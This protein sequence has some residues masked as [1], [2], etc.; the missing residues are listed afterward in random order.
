MPSIRFFV[1]VYAITLLSLPHR[2]YSDPVL[3][4]STRLEVTQPV[5]GQNWKLF[6]YSLLPNSEFSVYATSPSHHEFVIAQGETDFGGFAEVGITIAEL[7]G[8]VGQDL[9]IHVVV[10]N[11]Q[12]SSASEKSY[13]QFSG[14]G[15]ENPDTAFTP[16]SLEAFADLSSNG[17][18]LAQDFNGDGWVDLLVLGSDTEGAVLRLVLND[19]EGR[20]SEIH[21]HG[22]GPSVVTNVVACAAG[23]VDADGDVDLVLTTLESEDLNLLFLNDGTGTFQAADSFPLKSASGLRA[24][25]VNLTDVNGDGSLDILFCNGIAEAHDTGEPVPQPNEI[26]INDGMGQFEYLAEFT[27]DTSLNPPGLSR[28]SAVA[29]LNLDGNADILFAPLGCANRLLL[30]DGEGGFTDASELLLEAEESTYRI[31]PADVDLDGDLDLILANT[32][33]NP[34]AQTLLI[35]Q[36]GAQEGDYGVFAGPGFGQ[37]PIPQEGQSPIR[38][39]LYVRDVDADG[40]QDVIFTVHEL[41]GFRKTRSLYQPRWSTSWACWS[42]PTGSQFPSTWR[43]FQYSNLS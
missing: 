42:V 15:I 22:I 25:D 29:D 28:S 24:R 11:D 39:G 2:A 14:V 13:V 12:A 4:P 35:N 5:L 38:L 16:N 20:L 33:F 1:L 40:D 41:G 19:G 7:D 26:L 18:S 8:L 10:S 31:E 34:F 23:D 27:G 21:P 36:G 43:Y 37:F 6:V 3:S 30:G 17:F 9:Q 32:V